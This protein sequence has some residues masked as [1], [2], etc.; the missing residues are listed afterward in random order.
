LTAPQGTFPENIVLLIISP[1]AHLIPLL[2]AFDMSSII[3]AAQT[4]LPSHVPSVVARGTQ[5]QH[6]NKPGISGG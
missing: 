6:Y 3:I 4:L 1:M 5:K 2:F